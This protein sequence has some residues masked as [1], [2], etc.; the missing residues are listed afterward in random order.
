MTV[1]T[2]TSR[3][4]YAGNGSTTTF[5]VNFYFLSASDLVLIKVAADGTQTT[6][7][8]NTDYT[9]TGAGVSTGGSVTLTAAP[10]TGQTLVI[11]RDPALTQ[12]TD[13][14]ANDPFPAET[15]ERALDKLTMIA[16][17]LKD[18]LSRSLSFSDG[19]TTTASA[20]LPSP[21][22]NKLIGWNPT[23]SGLQNVD[24]LTIATQ[25]TAGTARSDLFSGDGST[26]SFV[27]SANPGAQPNLDVS[28]SGVSQR[29]GIDYTWTSGTTLTFVTAPPSGT[30]NILVRYWL[31]L[32]LGTSDSASALFVQ[33]GTSAVQ[34]MAQD[35]LREVVSVK[36]FGAA[37]DGVTDDTAA[38]QAALNAKSAAGGGIVYAPQGK[39]RLTSK[40]TIPSWVLFKG[41]EW[42]PDPSNGAQV[43]ATSLYI[44]WGD[45]ADN[46]AV[47][48]SASSGIEGFT[49]YY[50]TQVANTASTPTAFGFSISTPLAA[51]IYDNIHVKNITL[52][53]SYKG[54]RLNNGGRWRVENIQG[55]PLSVGFTAAGCYDVCYLRGVHFWT[56]YTQSNTLATWVR[57]NGTAFD[58]GRIDQLF[59]SDLFGYDYNVCFKFGA[60]LWASFNKILCDL[61]NTP[62]LAAGHSQV[63]VSDFV[64]ISNSSSAP[65]VWVQSGGTLNFSNGEITSTAGVGAQIDGG[66]EVKFNNITFANQ[67][68]AVVCTNATTDVYVDNSRWSVPPFGTY[69]VR[70]NGERLPKNSTSITLPA[71]ITAPTAISGGYQFDLSTSGA[72]TLQYE[73][74]Y[75]SERNSLFILEF[76]YE[77][78]G[79]PSTWYFQF[80]IQTDVGTATQ[81]AFS[82]LFPLILNGTAGSPK[83]VRIPFFINHGRFR[84]VMT[85]LVTPTATVAG[86]SLKMT[87]IVL[88]EQD[89]QYTTDAQVSNMMRA[90]Y[91]LDA[92]SM[93]QT[94]FAKGKNR[95]VL[96]Q[97]EAGIGRSTEAPIAGTWAQGDEVRVYNPA[98]AGYIGYVCTTAGTPGT[99]KTFGL[100]S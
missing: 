31:G 85:I 87:N 84:Q 23:A 88:Y 69:N 30:S 40:I 39:Y 83:T 29:P 72:K 65:A 55:N 98:S 33:S 12:T 24:P 41:A 66:T 61:A 50:P 46:H 71:P 80:N 94:L 43:F 68:A 18:I 82:P 52:Y 21:S 100:I 59:A 11:F 92:Y 95:I 44:N 97:S 28:I 26:R 13:Y 90:G 9:V 75:I 19:D 27:L 67:H 64:L 91:N 74:T 42:L 99:W 10:A 22:A 58:F 8:M 86:A 79:S 89:N 4:T 32:P 38:I 20:T 63:H 48:M 81:V 47:E 78:V 93:G 2:T 54:I 17:R 36:D 57:A 1:S 34:R 25:V 96:T 60:N 73:T 5:P 6:L 62:I 35:K 45:G 49:F 14:Q 7:A 16:Q 51:G 37:G 15:H 70:V 77:L 53:N 76:S 56:F 3:L